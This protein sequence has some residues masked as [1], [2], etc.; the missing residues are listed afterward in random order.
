MPQESQAS[1]SVSQW[2]TGR[3]QSAEPRQGDKAKGREGVER[4]DQLTH[5]K[6]KPRWRG[7]CEFDISEPISVRKAST[8]SAM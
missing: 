8:E 4:K 1:V 5:L 6:V 7:S 3:A 2:G